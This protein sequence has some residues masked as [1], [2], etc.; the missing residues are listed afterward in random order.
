MAEVV[1][2]MAYQWDCNRVESCAE[3][4]ALLN[5][6]ITKLYHN[7]SNYVTLEMVIRVKG[8]GSSEK[9]KQ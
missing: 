4:S 7:F 6:I 3:R 9:S 8:Q 1:N 2:Y 5:Y